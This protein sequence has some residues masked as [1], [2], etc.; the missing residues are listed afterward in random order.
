MIKFSRLPIRHQLIFLAILLTLPAIGVIIYSGL[1]ERAEDYR[2]AQIES[3]R[4]VDNL[5]AEMQNMVD[6][7]KQLSRV[8]ADLPEVHNRDTAKVK[9]IISNFLKENEQYLNILFA[10]ANGT[11]WGATHTFK[12]QETVADRRYFRNARE[13][14]SFSSGE[15]VISRTTGKPS[16]HFAYPI[17]GA[18]GEFQGAIIIGF[19]ID[20]LRSILERGQLSKTANYII[21]DHKGIILSRGRNLGRQVGEPIQPDDLKTMTAGPERSTYEFTRSDGERRIVTYRKLVLDAESTPYVYIRGGM[22]INDAMSAANRKMLTNIALLMP[23]VIVAFLLAIFIGRRS[24]VNRVNQLQAAAQQIIN[25][26]LNSRVGPLVEGGELGELGRAF[27][28]M[29]E[30]L[31]DKISKLVQTQR[32]LR[33]KASLLEAEITERSL[34][35]ENLAVKQGQL[36]ALNQTLEE[37]VEQAV[38]ELRQKDQALIQQNRLAAMGEMIG[39]IAHQWRHPLH[40]I[41]L[42]VQILPGEFEELSPAE[43]EERVGQIMNIIMQMSQT[44]DDFTNFFH[45]DK[46]KTS[47]I[48]H[49]AVVKAVEFNSPSLDSKGIA[50]AVEGDREVSVFG[51]HNEYLQVLLNILNNAKDALIQRA[52][53]GPRISITISRRDQRS[54]VTIADNGGGIDESIL[55][56]IFDPYFTTKGPALGTGIGLYMSKT[57]IE[58][59]MGGL[60]KVRNIPNG[61]EFSI[62]V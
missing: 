24:I 20:I 40:N 29:A 62:E 7:A 22:A 46:E 11:I 36:E 33:D 44:I 18:H 51:Y 56:K 31:D 28:D 42:L 59:N 6:E 41:G 55:P 43:L 3:Q 53:K 12:P 58:Q 2:K 45:R 37:R 9:P 54:V 32:E 30:A 16:L 21:T 38:D 52:V 15:Y 35:Q 39:N 27:D 60:L 49:T 10:D 14:R 5:A 47:F 1:R 48:A 4:L 34:A 26:N 13:T 23:F 17:L 19:N 8:F 50:V 61:A 57:I 25:G